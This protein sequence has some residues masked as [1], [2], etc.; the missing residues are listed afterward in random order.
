MLESH[1]SDL[2]Q[3]VNTN[4]PKY[5]VLTKADHNKM[6]QDKDELQQKIISMQ[7]LVLSLQK[8]LEAKNTSGKVSTKNST[9]G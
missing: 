2:P 6:L 9:G 3:T 7:N 5:V 1:R 8:Q 4:D